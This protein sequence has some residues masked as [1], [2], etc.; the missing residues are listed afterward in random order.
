MHARGIA[1][2]IGAVMAALLVSGCGA[3]EPGSRSA[4]TVDALT[5]SVGAPVLDASAATTGQE[6]L[7]PSSPSSTEQAADSAPSADTLRA[8]LD[9][10]EDFRPSFVHGDKTAA[11]QRYIV[12]HDTEGDSSPESVVSWWDSNGS[13]VAAHFVVGKDGHIVQCVPLDKIAHHAGYGDAGHNEAFGIEEDG[14]DDMAGT[15][16][17]GA[18]CPDYAMNAWSVGIE[19]VHVGGEGDYPPE[20]LKAL[21]KLIA[22]I[23]AY[24]GFESRITDHNA[25]RT[26][27]SDTSSEFAAYLANYQD[28]RTHD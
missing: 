7:E 27:N 17:I 21:D 15:S 23:D 4:S 1:P 20:Q 22:Y 11:N 18:A 28:H 9:L 14:R 3:V 5:P 6:A 16:P 12:L 2:F 19:L 26:G 8:E 25:W 13:L 10:T 24:Y